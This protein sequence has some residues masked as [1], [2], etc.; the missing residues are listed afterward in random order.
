MPKNANLKNIKDLESHLAVQNEKYRKLGYSD[1]DDRVY[2]KLYEELRLLYEKDGLAIPPESILSGVGL[3][4]KSHKK[5]QHAIRMY[6]LNNVYSAEDAFK[7]FSR[8]IEGDVEMHASVKEDGAALKIIYKLGRLK[9][10][11]TRGDGKDGI[12]VTDKFGSGSFTRVIGHKP[13]ITITGEL[14]LNKCDLEKVSEIAGVKFKTTRHA[15]VAYLN[16]NSPNPEILKYLIFVAYDVYGFPETMHH[17]KM[18][19]LQEL[20]FTVCEGI[21]FKFRDFSNFSKFYKECL[22]KNKNRPRET[23]GVVL[24]VGD[25]KVCEKMGYTQRAPRFAVAVK[26]LE[27]GHLAF[28]STIEYTIGDTGIVTPVVGL[29]DP[30]EIDGVTVRKVSMH[31][32]SRLKEMGVTTGSGVEVILAGKIIP[33]IRSVLKPGKTDLNIPEECWM[34]KTPF[35]VSGKHYRCSSPECAASRQQKSNETSDT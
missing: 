8:K 22:K 6:S 35:T 12:E 13:E 18:S 9:S 29:M 20:G 31:S 19:L 30:V 3:K 28:V 1:I 33:H 21:H 14:T 11:I 17:T 26:F 24:R 32:V 7:Y 5:V 27:D 4:P 2:D 23:D 10:V 25:P 16:S 34:C 15:V